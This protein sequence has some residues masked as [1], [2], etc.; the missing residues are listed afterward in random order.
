MAMGSQRV[1]RFNAQG[2]ATL[3]PRYGGGPQPRYDASQRQR[4]LSEVTRKPEP[5][6]DGA[7]TW[8]LKTLQRALRQAPDG[9]P[10]GSTATIGQI[11]Q[12]AG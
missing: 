7:A 3:V 12:A 4:I 6:R 11:L 5:K 9:L 2:L 10:Q 8:S 1:A